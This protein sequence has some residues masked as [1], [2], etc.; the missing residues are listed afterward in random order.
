MDQIGKEAYINM[1]RV[2]QD[3]IVEN[4]RTFTVQNN[5]DGTITL[6]PAPGQIIQAGTPVNAANLNGIETDLTN[7][8]LLSDDIRGTIAYPT[9][10]NGK[11]TQIQHK[12]GSNN[13]VR[14]DTF[15][16]TDTLITEIR[17]MTGG[18]SLTLKYYFDTSGNYIR[19]EVS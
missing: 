14:T 15:T 6:I 13:V 5:A 18:S 16:Y 19:T 12:D 17:T 1:G 3:R 2:W 9:F 7:G 4:P 10:T 8:I 11:I